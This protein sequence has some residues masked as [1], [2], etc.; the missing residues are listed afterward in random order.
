MLRTNASGL[1]SVCRYDNRDLVEQRREWRLI[2]V[3]KEFQFLPSLLVR[4]PTAFEAL[5]GWSMLEP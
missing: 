5:Q 2:R 4:C 3:N 1:L